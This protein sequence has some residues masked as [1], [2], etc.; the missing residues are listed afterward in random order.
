LDD[1][2]KAQENKNSRRNTDAKH[3]GGAARSNEEVSVMEME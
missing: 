3:W 2:G 1:K